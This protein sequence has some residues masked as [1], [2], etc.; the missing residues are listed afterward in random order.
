MSQPLVLRDTYGI[1]LRTDGSVEKLETKPSFKECQTIVD[2]YIIWIKTRWEDLEWQAIMDEDGHSKNLPVNVKASDACG[3][4]V[5]G[6][7]I[8]LRGSFRQ[9]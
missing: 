9:K 1:V 3:F 4:I 8:L 5:F 7:T 2:G 6:T